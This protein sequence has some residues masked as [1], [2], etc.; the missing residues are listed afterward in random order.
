MRKYTHAQTAMLYWAENENKDKCKTCGVSRWV[1]QEKKGSAANNEPEKLIH[2]VPQNVM[3][4]FP[5]KPR[6]QRMFMYKDFSQ[7]MTWHAVGRKKDGKLRHP[8][9]GKAWKMMDAQYPDF[10]RKIKM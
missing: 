4:Y 6:V 2:K 10:A 3:R 8:A 5:L 9:D 1:V 7:L